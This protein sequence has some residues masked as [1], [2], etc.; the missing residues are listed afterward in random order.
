MDFNVLRDVLWIILIPVAWLRGW[1]ALSLLPL[2]ISFCLCLLIIVGVTVATDISY[3]DYIVLRDTLIDISFVI[4]DII[5]AVMVIEKRQPTSR[6]IKTIFKH[7]AISPG[8]SDSEVRDAEPACA[9]ADPDTMAGEQRK[10]RCFRNKSVMYLY[11]IIFWLTT[12]VLVTSV[13]LSTFAV[14]PYIMGERMATPEIKYITIITILAGLI[15]ASLAIKLLAGK[16]CISDK[17]VYSL[18]P[19]LMGGV[20]FCKEGIYTMRRLSVDRYYVLHPWTSLYLKEADVRNCRIRLLDGLSMLNIQAL[21]WDVDDAECL[22]RM[23]TVAQVY[24]PGSHH[25]IPTLR[26]WLNRVTVLAVI[27]IFLTGYG[28]ILSYVNNNST[29][30][31]GDELCDIC[32]TSIVGFVSPQGFQ[33]IQNG[34]CV[35]EYCVPH[36]FV[37]TLAHPIEVL[38]AMLENLIAAG[39]LAVSIYVLAMFV[40]LLAIFLLVKVIKWGVW[41][42]EN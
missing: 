36:M 23:Q 6:N 11:S 31:A 9:T 39:I 2:P 40:W 22:K 32:G 14:V 19:D 33:M 30:K 37:F 29:G 18:L 21:S 4:T 24:M 15:L 1:K 17:A 16:A 5:L 25:A 26:Y 13:V 27:V 35:R 3:S 10:I 7:K 28:T 34:I 41:S 42:F 20:I 38:A 12:I 8:C